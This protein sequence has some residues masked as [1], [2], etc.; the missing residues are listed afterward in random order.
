MIVTCPNCTAR[1]KVP[2]S[3]ITDRGAKI[4]CPNCSHKFIVK[5]N[6]EAGGEEMSGA[7]G[8]AK[9]PG[10]LARRDFRKVGITWKVRKGI[11]LTYDFIDLSTL[12]EYMS[13]AQVSSADGLSWDQKTYVKIG[14]IPSLEA[15]FWDVWQRAERGEIASPTA[16]KGSEEDESDAATT[17]VGAGSSL[18]E[19]IRRAVSDLATPPPAQARGGGTP[20]PASPSG[21]TSKTPAPAAPPPPAAPTAPAAPDPAFQKLSEK[22]TSNA[23]AGAAVAGGGIMLAA[24]G[25]VVLLLLLLPVVLYLLGF[26][27]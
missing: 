14:E 18:A 24:G 26:F 27:R 16:S 9:I 15:H 3:K 23:A 4:T 25:I 19:E 20:A 22:K 7:D 21:P 10:D 5:A 12:H 6:G 1:Y 13:D 2:E 8:A 11:G 17:I